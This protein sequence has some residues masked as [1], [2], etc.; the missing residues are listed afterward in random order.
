MLPLVA[1][2][3]GK[4]FGQPRAEVEL[5]GRRAIVPSENLEDRR[6]IG[7]A[8]QPERAQRPEQQPICI[9]HDGFGCEDM[10]TEMLVQALQPRG[11]VGRVADYAVEEVPT[12][13]GVPNIHVAV[14]QPHAWIEVARPM[15]LRK[16]RDN[17]THFDG[18][19]HSLA[20]NC[21]R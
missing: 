4:T 9:S 13:A 14:L 19:F 11:G 20:A 5:V 12:S 17:F 1:L 3:G 2:K 18:R 8:A 16:A 15:L 7:L 6:W 21:R 10:R